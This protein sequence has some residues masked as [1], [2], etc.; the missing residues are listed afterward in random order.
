MINLVTTMSR[1]LMILLIL[2][3]TYYNF[4]F[5]SL[6][7]DESKLRL[8]R[9]QNVPLFLI[10]LLS[11]TIIYLQTEDE[12][13]VLFFGAQLVFFVLYQ[14]LYRLFYRNAS[15]LLLNNT[16]ML[17]CTSFIML[18]RISMDKA[19]RQFIIMAVAA[20]I[21]MIIPYVIRPDRSGAAA[22][23]LCDRQYQLRRAAFDQ[24]RRVFVP[25]VRVC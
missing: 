20:V 18:T 17:L 6:P 22:G 23:C 11:G 2:I 13:V 7:D 21:T 4:R 16:C 12:A 14:L 25:A 9:L 24:Y 10:F 15:R 5:F 19:V 1:Y 3:Y 8:C